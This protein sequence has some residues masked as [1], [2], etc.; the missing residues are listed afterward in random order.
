[1]AERWHLG[2]SPHKTVDSV[3]GS[4]TRQVTVVSLSGFE[5]KLTIEK[6]PMLFN[7]DS[8]EQLLVACDCQRP[9]PTIAKG[10]DSVTQRNYKADSPN[11]QAQSLR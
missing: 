6:L 7:P 2:T 9:A 1:M 11:M 5:P 10:D 3:A 4:G 8:L